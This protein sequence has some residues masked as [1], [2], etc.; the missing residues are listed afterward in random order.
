MNLIKIAKAFFK[1]DA[2]KAKSWDIL[3]A[4]F[5]TYDEAYADIENHNTCAN[6]RYAAR[7]ALYCAPLGSTADDAYA[8]APYKDS[9]FAKYTEAELDAHTAAINSLTLAFDA[10]NAVFDAVTFTEK[11]NLYATAVSYFKLNCD[12]YTFAC[13]AYSHAASIAALDASEGNVKAVRDEWQVILLDASAANASEV[14]AVAAKTKAADARAKAGAVAA[15]SKAL[16]HKAGA[17]EAKAKVIQAKAEAAEAKATAI[18]RKIEI[19]K[20]L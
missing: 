18:A 2:T 19:N 6:H 14:N 17:A 1:A 4:A 3:D 8:A 10:L 16:E 12:R 5:K 13:A 7:S 11:K 9:D 20:D 15:K